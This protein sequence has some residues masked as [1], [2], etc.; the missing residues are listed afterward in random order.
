MILTSSCEQDPQKC[1]V[2]GVV[3]RKSKLRW[4]RLSGVS[5]KKYNVAL[6]FMKFYSQQFG[7]EETVEQPCFLFT[8]LNNVKFLL[9]AFKVKVIR[10]AG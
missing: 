2:S 1:V 10:L 3:P 9:L 5:N 7:T 8:V 4:M 6:I